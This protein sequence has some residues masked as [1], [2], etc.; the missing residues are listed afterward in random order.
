[1]LPPPFA[2]LTQLALVHPGAAVGDAADLLRSV[3][4]PAISQPHGIVKYHILSRGA[5]KKQV[6]GEFSTK[7]ARA[8]TSHLRFL[9]VH[10][11]G[12]TLSNRDAVFIWYANLKRLP[13]T[14]RNTII[15]QASN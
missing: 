9:L 10:R 1:M 15:S 13:D 7:A 3:H 8:T 5:E 14:V 11:R 12:G 4:H 6:W 2:K